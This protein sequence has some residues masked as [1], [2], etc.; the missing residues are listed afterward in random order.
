MLKVL[1]IMYHLLFPTFFLL[2]LQDL[3]HRLRRIVFLSQLVVSMGISFP[4]IQ[5]LSAFYALHHIFALPVLDSC[6]L[7]YSCTAIQGYFPSSL[8]IPFDA[9]RQIRL[10]S[11][12]QK[13]PLEIEIHMTSCEHMYI[14]SIFPVC[15]HV[16][17]QQKI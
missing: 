7:K 1:W 11:G 13:F 9:P 15:V 2:P 10:Q 8:L 12:S 4:Y 16:I 5:S 6:W 17:G 14:V 3:L